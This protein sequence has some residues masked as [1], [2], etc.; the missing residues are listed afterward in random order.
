MLLVSTQHSLPEYEDA[1][2]ARLKEIL[3]TNALEVN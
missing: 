1:H 3:D 2:V